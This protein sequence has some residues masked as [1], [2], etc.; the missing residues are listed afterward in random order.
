MIPRGFL[1]G[2]A[3][4]I[5]HALFGLVLARIADSWSSQ[6]LLAIA[7]T[8]WTAITG[9]NAM[10]SNFWQLLL[11]RIGVS[12]GGRLGTYMAQSP[13]SQPRVAAPGWKLLWDELR[14][15]LPPFNTWLLWRDAQRGPLLRRNMALLFAFSLVVFALSWWIG[16][17]LQWSLPALGCYA[18]ATWLQLLQRRDPELAELFIRRHTLI[19]LAMGCGFISALNTRFGMWMAPF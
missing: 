5:F 17:P 18:T 16:D 13:S 10:A 11:A 9:L 8:V 15:A 14:A 4:A 1:F 3:F 19:W 2:T 6:G 12:V 7:L